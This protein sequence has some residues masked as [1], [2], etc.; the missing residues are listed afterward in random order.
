VRNGR[1]D[2]G[3]SLS[4][5][6]RLPVD[7]YVCIK[8]PLD[9]TLTRVEGNLFRLI[10]PPVR[11]FN[12]DVSPCVSCEV[13]QDNEAVIIESSSVVLS[14]SKYVVGLNGCYNIKIKTVFG[15]VDNA[16]K[17]SILSS[18][19]IY[20]EVDP[21]PPF[22]YFNRR[23]LETTGTLA[24]SIAL[25]QIENAFVS[26]LATDYER[27]AVDENYRMERAASCAVPSCDLPSPSPS[28]APASA[29]EPVAAP[30]AV[31]AVASS[32]T[33]PV[34]P[35][36]KPKPKPKGGDMFSPLDA[37]NAGSVSGLQ[38][39]DGP[40]V[41]T[42][43]ICLVPGDPVV[44]IEEAPANSRRIFTGVDISASV[45]DVWAVLVDYENLQNVIPSLV[46]NKVVEKRADGGARLEQV[47]GAKVLPGVTFTAKVALD[48]NL[49]LEENPLP[50]DMQASHLP[51]TAASSAVRAYDMQLPLV[52]GVFPRP[53]AITS[54]PFRDITM[55]NVEGEGD[56][57]H[58]QGIWRM[59]SLPNCAPDGSDACRLTYAVEIRP[60]GFL[61]VRLIEGR[62]ASD[63]RENLGAIRKVVE[64][65]VAS[66][67]KAQRAV[68]AGGEQGDEEAE[69][70]AL[71]GMGR[72][73]EEQGLARILAGA[74]R[75]AAEMQAE[76]PAP[77]PV[78]P[79]V[80][81]AEAETE[82]EPS[83]GSGAVFSPSLNPLTWFSSSGGGGDRAARERLRRKKAE[84][85]AEELRA[86]VAELEKEIK[87]QGQR[88]Q[89]IRNMSRPEE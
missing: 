54:L 49:Y 52:R 79:A 15:W 21:P 23:L 78:A 10:V 73:D 32:V 22:K 12:L 87:R 75:G 89:S 45:A 69:A 85:E 34:T 43:D 88:L 27:W 7:Q 57:E 25:R 66:R 26:S 3:V 63:L 72:V 46:R 61:P 58:Y 80:A 68:S 64:Q 38:D 50:A 9:A 35:K 24:M 65:R 1:R 41:L 81:E 42:D 28:P 55:Q 37:F 19:K 30:A 56:F 5:Y 13:T 4:D 6:M 70:E 2:P 86:R 60:K 53:Y 62:I 40:A 16:E 18:S 31:A 71:G 48:V 20:V 36:P 14:G 44:R 82:A 39:G 17:Q 84:A 59:Q 77:A 29:P 83:V 74:Q 47:G 11:F 8:M 76:P 51:E 67:L 33:A